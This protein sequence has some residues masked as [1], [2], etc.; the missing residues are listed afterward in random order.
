MQC[1]IGFIGGGNMAEA[2]V[3]A[4]LTSEVLSADRVIVADPAD[5]RRSVF[6]ALGVTTTT[7]NA[8]VIAEARQIVLAVKPQMFATVAP[9]LG[10]L[11]FDEQIVVSIMAGISSQQIAASIGGPARVI[12]VMPNTP[13]MIGEGM[14]GVALGDQARQGDEQLAM[15][16]LG[17]AGKALVVPE[18]LIDAVTAVSGSGPAYVFYLAEAMAEAA[19]ELGLGNEAD[20][21][22][23]QTIVG[24]AKLLSETSE[25]PAALRRKV[26]SPGGTTEAAINHME[27]HGVRRNIADA[28]GKA[29]QRGRQLGK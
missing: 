24:A 11:D 14:A 2:M 16:L 12:R 19:K 28:L 22:V 9:Q 27:S 4:G 1:Q 17:A 25:S 18:S 8:Q 10:D 5:E 29:E 3:R 7:N 26:T 13:M 6:E 20:L 23:R 21:L 15:R